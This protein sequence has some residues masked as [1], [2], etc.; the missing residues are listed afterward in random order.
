MGFVRGIFF[1]EVS[2]SYHLGEIGI[3]YTIDPAYEAEV[4]D[5]LGWPN[6][7]LLTASSNSLLDYRE[8]VV[9]SR[10][11]RGGPS[12]TSVTQDGYTMEMLDIHGVNA[13]GNETV[14]IHN[15]S[16]FTSYPH[17]SQ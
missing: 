9:H 14:I 13:D 10:P 17:P 1:L 6:F 16:A 8:K 15:V 5:Y 2:L 12:L 11:F 3:A 4:R 7:S